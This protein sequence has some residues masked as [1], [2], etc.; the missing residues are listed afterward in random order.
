MTDAWIRHFP[1]PRDCD[2]CKKLSSFC[3]ETGA[4]GASQGSQLTLT[5]KGFHLS[6]LKFSKRLPTDVPQSAVL[7]GPE[8]GHVSHGAKVAWNHAG[9]KG[10]LFRHR[11]GLQRGGAGGLGGGPGGCT[12]PGTHRAWAEQGFE[13]HCL[14]LKGRIF[15][16]HCYLLCFTVL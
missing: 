14:H 2:A 6:P 5:H 16:L 1:P 3:C 9:Q 12:L 8:G 10:A 15:A 13:K 11:A 7:C 4:I